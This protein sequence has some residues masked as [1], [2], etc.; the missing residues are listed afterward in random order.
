MI[1]HLR[2]EHESVFEDGSGAMVVS[3]GK[4]H[5]HLG[6]TLDCTVRG[7]VSVTVFEHLEEMLKVFD[8]A[9]PKG[10][11]TKSSAA[12]ANLFAVRSSQKRRLWNFTHCLSPSGPG[13]TPAPLSPS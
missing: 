8:E 9:E 12:S 7:Q 4:T 1:K 6:M 11:G 3:Q 2:Q 5:K 13:R 10:C